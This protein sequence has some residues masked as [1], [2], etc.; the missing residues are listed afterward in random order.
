MARPELG[1]KRTCTECGTK[2]Y[3][4][5]KSPIVCPK[6]GTELDLASVTTAT[7]SRAKPQKAA[8]PAP[9]ADE[10]DN[11]E[12][13]DEE[14]V[15]LEDVDAEQTDT[16]RASTDLEEDEDIPDLEEGSDDDSDD[17][18][19]DEFLEDDDDNDDV[20]GLVEGDRD[21]EEE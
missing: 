17:D 18:D 16:G 20:S 2:F 9:V 6:C 1:T 8:K 5:N 3:D 12:E 10:D 4:L 21:D 13:T 11:T 19:S 14:T 7:T 15:A